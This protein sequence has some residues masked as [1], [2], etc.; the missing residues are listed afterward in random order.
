MP[1][2][3][4]DK[5]ASPRL[6]QRHEHYARPARLRYSAQKFRFL[7]LEATRIS[8]SFAGIFNFLKSNSAFE[9][10]QVAGTGNL[11]TDPYSA[12]SA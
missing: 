11:T 12:T 4:P 6:Y 3:V 7:N 5:S 2:F 8:S 9:I 10:S 1:I